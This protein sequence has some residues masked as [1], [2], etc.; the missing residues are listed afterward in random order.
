MLSYLHH[1]WIIDALQ[2]LVGRL[3]KELV[4]TSSTKVEESLSPPSRDMPRG[5]VSLGQD[6]LHRIQRVYWH[7]ASNVGHPIVPWRHNADSP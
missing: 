3:R 6:H 5:C 1:A 4:P 2:M 7:L